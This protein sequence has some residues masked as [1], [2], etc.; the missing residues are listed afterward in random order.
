MSKKSQL[1]LI[2]L[3]GNESQRLSWAY[4]LSCPFQFPFQAEEWREDEWGR[5]KKSSDVSCKLNY[6]KEN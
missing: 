1:K 5:L 2:R 3:Y 4:F 6:E